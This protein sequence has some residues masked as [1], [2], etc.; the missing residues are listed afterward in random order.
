MFWILQ[1]LVKRSRGEVWRKKANFIHK[2]EM[3]KRS[4]DGEWN[5]AWKGVRGNLARGERADTSKHHRCRKACVAEH[6]SGR[7]DDHLAATS[8]SPGG[9][10]VDVQGW[11]W[12]AA[13]QPS[14]RWAFAQ[15]R[16]VRAPSSSPLSFSWHHPSVQKD[17][18][19]WWITLKL[20][21][22][23]RKWD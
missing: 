1:S 9:S 14:L 3:T 7:S 21:E 2:Q 5:P 15:V 8:V 10:D 12:P 23:L 19:G 20:T 18:K 4:L 13:P 11:E 6:A 16:R 22:H 17:E